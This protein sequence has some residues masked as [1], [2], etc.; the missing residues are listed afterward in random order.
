MLCDLCGKQ[1]A[2]VHLTE[3]IDGES[4]ELHLCQTCAHKKGVDAPEASDLSGLLAGLTDLGAAK[5]KLSK[6]AS[7][8]ICSRC[9]MTYED[10]RKS[11]RLGCAGCYS[12]FKVL[13][14]PL[15]RRIH[16]STHHVGKKPALIV[17]RKKKT[18]AAGA[19]HPDDL[20]RLKTQLKKAITAEAFEQAAE[21][22]DRIQALK[23][24]PKKRAKKRDS[25]R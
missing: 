16:G 22:R 12:S 21:L 6:T 10:F 4:R 1:E 11:G 2:N 25:A 14:S 15:L 17:E 13:L 9:G 23:T 5:E 18:R 20:T 19:K 8:L 24:K 3:I 7:K